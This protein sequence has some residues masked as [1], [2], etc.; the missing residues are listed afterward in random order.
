MRSRNGNCTLS[1]SILSLIFLSS[2]ALNASDYLISYRYVVKD[3]ALLN[4]KLSISKAMTRCKGTLSKAIIIDNHGT[5]NL[6]HILSTHNEDFIEY[7]HKL[8]LDVQHND[9][10]CN[11]QN[12]ST[13]ILTLRTRCFKVDFNENFVKIAPF[14]EGYN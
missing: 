6:T 13:T 7:I 3:A 14:K 2:L 12:S 1:R 9:A 10:T 4:E 11:M 8:G 5:K